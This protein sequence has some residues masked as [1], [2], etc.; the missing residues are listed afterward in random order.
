MILFQLYKPLP[1]QFQTITMLNS[2]EFI[3]R[4]EILFEHYGLSAASFS[5]KIGIQ[6]SGISHLLS[7]RNKPSLDFVMK[8]IATFPEVDLYWLLTGEGN[9]VK[10]DN[11]NR[12]TQQNPKSDNAEKIVIFYPDGS[13]S[14]YS[15]K[16]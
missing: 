1:L 14:E 12:I 6:R 2:E 7:G 11:A 9:L 3:K 5:D 10:S 16:K 13:F 15:P 8:I 4:L